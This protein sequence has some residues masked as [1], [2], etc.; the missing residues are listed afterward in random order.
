MDQYRKRAGK[1]IGML[2]PG[3][4]MNEETLMKLR[5][6]VLEMLQSIDRELVLMDRPKFLAT[7]PVPPFNAYGGDPLPLIQKIQ[8]LDV[9]N[10]LQV[11]S[12]VKEIEEWLRH[13]NFQDEF[14]VVSGIG[15][16][17]CQVNPTKTQKY[18]NTIGY[19]LDA[20]RS[21]LGLN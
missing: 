11:A 20:L 4:P 1:M 16:A 5:E 18:L 8:S 6:E 13:F 21:R 12:V 10:G 15:L 3:I 19:T 9:S 17:R 14:Q 7:V 2:P